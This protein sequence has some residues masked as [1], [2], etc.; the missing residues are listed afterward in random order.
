M[1]EEVTQAEMEVPVS[2][3]AEQAVAFLKSGSSNNV[4]APLLKALSQM[5]DI[6][7]ELKA[8]PSHE[9][10][11]HNDVEYDTGLGCYVNLLQREFPPT[12]TPT[13]TNSTAAADVV[14]ERHT[15]TEKEK[16]RAVMP[17]DFSALATS[18]Q[19]PSGLG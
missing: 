6:S 14:K 5:I 4:P 18:F 8:N 11:T 15:E 9:V 19:A 1:S 7:R 13:T 16:E 2:N 17:I 3:G 10:N 12:P